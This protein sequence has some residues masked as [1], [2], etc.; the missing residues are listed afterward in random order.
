MDKAFSGLHKDTQDG[1][2]GVFQIKAN[3]TFEGSVASVYHARLFDLSSEIKSPFISVFHPFSFSYHQLENIVSQIIFPIF[4]IF[5]K[6]NDSS[7]GK[8]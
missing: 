1:V 6:E 2:G 4:L 5:F 3:H 7:P 8:H